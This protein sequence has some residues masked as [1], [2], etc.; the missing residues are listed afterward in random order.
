LDDYA[1]AAQLAQQ[2]A[3]EMSKLQLSNPKTG[4]VRLT[5]IAAAARLHDDA[6]AKSA[7]ADL[8]NA[9]PGLTSIYA[10]RKWIHP[11]ANLYGY[12]PLFDDL[13]LAGL[14]Q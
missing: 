14:P 5:L 12:K 8:A 10:V 3:A 4:S 7:I 1:K 11:Q 6:T 13:R 2:S 9:A